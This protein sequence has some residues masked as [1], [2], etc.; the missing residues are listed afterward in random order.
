[1]GMGKPSK[2][3]K[4]NDNKNNNV[5]IEEGY[6]G[7]NKKDKNKKKIEKVKLK[8]D[9]KKEEIITE[10]NLMVKMKEINNNDI[11]K[12]NINKIHKNNVIVKKKGKILKN[13]DNNNEDNN[14]INKKVDLNDLF[15]IKKS[16]KLDELNNKNINIENDNESDIS[17]NNID[18]KPHKRN[19]NLFNENQNNLLD[20][21]ITNKEN[22]F[23]NIIFPLTFPKQIINEL[24]QLHLNNKA[25]QNVYKFEFKEYILFIYHIKI[26]EEEAGKEELKPYFIRYFMNEYYYYYCHINYICNKNNFIYNI[27]WKTKNESIFE[28]KLNLNKFN[29]SV[30]IHFYYLYLQTLNED[31][32]I[33]KD[34]L[35]EQIERLNLDIKV[36]FT[37]FLF[38]LIKSIQLKNENLIKNC[39]D[40]FK[41]G[42]YKFQYIKI[43]NF[44]ISE[45]D[46]KK[47]I[48]NKEETEEIKSICN[49]NNTFFDTIKII[50][51]MRYYKNKFEKYLDDNL[52]KENIINIIFNILEIN[53]KFKQG[54]IIEKKVYDKLIKV[55]NNKENIKI[56]YLQCYSLLNFFYVNL[57]YYDLV[58]KLFQNDVIK[59][60][61]YINESLNK[62][63][64]EVSDFIKYYNKIIEKE[65][66]LGF[67]FLDFNEIIFFYINKYKNNQIKDFQDLI[68]IINKHKIS[69]VINITKKAIYE[70]IHNYYLNLAKNG[71]IHSHEILELICEKDEFYFN[72]EFNSKENRSIEIFDGIKIEKEKNDFFE[73]F[74]RRK[75]WEYFEIF[76]EAFIFYFLFLDYFPKK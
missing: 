24:T 2:V 25:I 40:L 43:D 30:L 9:K 69:N 63:Y 3:V 11:N 36:E 26:K 48:I 46:I 4:E 12:N 17:F 64:M 39:I 35:F 13:I 41:N 22:E 59:V 61:D 72:N 6:V 62:E 74:Q 10:Y 27:N 14:N 19:N 44:I 58:S 57:T 73:E 21:T 76:N 15:D 55:A 51:L 68:Y 70:L 31:N 8:P 66:E 23:T 67:V 54:I 50:L 20:E 65:R 34:L 75:I 28:N 32:E 45:D 42:S 16:T 49:E 47:Y 53:E 56:L 29:Q 37:D 5:V 52:K 71:S 38:L 33:I 18:E 60:I 7:G 1:M